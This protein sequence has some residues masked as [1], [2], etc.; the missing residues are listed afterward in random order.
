M[1]RL[2]YLLVAVLVALAG[3]AFHIRNKQDIVLDYFAG[4]VTVELSLVV[5]ASL[6]AG[7]LLGALVT[8]STVLRLKAEI[9]RLKRRQQIAGRE[10]ASLRAI[11]AKDVP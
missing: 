10:L 5:V 7:V 11:S 2:I 4:T 6:V 9:R 3:L 8:A 1:T